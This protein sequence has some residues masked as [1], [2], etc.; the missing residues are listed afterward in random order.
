VD[1]KTS[2]GEIKEKEIQVGLETNEYIEVLEGLSEQ[3]L[4]LIPQAK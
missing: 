1:I 3:D 2:D 4:I